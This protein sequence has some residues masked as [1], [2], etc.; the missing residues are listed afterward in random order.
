MFTDYSLIQA[1]KCL[2]TDVHSLQIAVAKESATIATLRQSDAEVHSNLTTVQS[3]LQH[4][5]ALRAEEK[6]ALRQELTNLKEIADNQIRYADLTA[7]LVSD[8]K[9]YWWEA[10]LLL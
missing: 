9:N 1:H 10:V 3:Q 5:Q 4:E 8:L 6:C 2:A 7:C